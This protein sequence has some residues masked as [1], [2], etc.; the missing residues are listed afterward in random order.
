MPYQSP[1]QALPYQLASSTCVTNAISISS[2]LRPVQ[3][4]SNPITTTQIAPSNT[5]PLNAKSYTSNRNYRPR[6]LITPIPLTSTELYPL[7]LERHLMAP[8]FLCLLEPP[9]PHWYDINAMC[10]YHSGATRH[11]LENCTAFKCKVQALLNNGKIQFNVN[12]EPSVSSNPLLEHRK[13]AV[14]AT[15]MD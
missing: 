10:T 3:T 6:P 1:Y 5:A 4:Q 2:T 9:Y 8:I 15:N 11:D 13:G 14:N 7:L 12:D